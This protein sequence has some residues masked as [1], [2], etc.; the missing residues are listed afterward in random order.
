MLG[1][2]AV[3]LMQTSKL[4]SPLKDMNPPLHFEAITFFM[5]KTVFSF[6]LLS[7]FP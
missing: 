7:N 5:L 6:H 1:K 4:P 2:D 3:L